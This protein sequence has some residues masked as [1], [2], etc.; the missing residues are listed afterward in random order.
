MKEMKLKKEIRLIG[1]LFV[2]VASTSADVVLK[3]LNSISFR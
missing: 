2:Y 1:S 3:G